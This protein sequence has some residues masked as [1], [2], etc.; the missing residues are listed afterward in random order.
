M[1]LDQRMQ[2]GL[3]WRLVLRLLLQAL[4]GGL[5]TGEVWWCLVLS[6]LQ[7]TASLQPWLRGIIIQLKANCR[8]STTWRCQWSWIDCPHP[9]SKPESQWK[10]SP[11]ETFGSSFSLFLKSQTWNQKEPVLLKLYVDSRACFD[12]ICSQDFIL[13]FKVIF[14]LK[15]NY[16]FG[17]FS[18]NKCLYVR[19]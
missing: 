9:I 6:L 4:S 12:D 13:H 19:F 1:P 10:S 14:Q 5:P 3:M 2:S 8:H 15:K 11:L 17:R 18:G 7:G 16:S